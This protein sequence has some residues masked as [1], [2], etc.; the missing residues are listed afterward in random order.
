MSSGIRQFLENIDLLQHAEA[1]ESNDVDIDLLGELDDQV[2]KD[3]GIASAGHR[4]RILR[5]I[6]GPSAPSQPISGVVSARGN[7]QFPSAAD[8]ER[9]QLTVMFCDL[10]G[11]P[12]LAEQ[13]DPEELRDLMQAYQHA[14]GDIVARYEGHVAQY[15]GD[16]LVV[17]FGWPRAHEDDAAR[18]IGA[19]LE[20]VDAVS[21]LEAAVPI[22]VRVG[23]HTGLV[24]IGETGNGDASIPGGAVGDTPPR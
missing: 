14:C 24:V 23:I 17:Y 2:L 6:K 8:A 19:A 5:A 3:I 12:D 15:R 16:G 9:R 21:Q 4:L 10:V 22:R 1:F 13:L 11:F 20:M 18:T 7:Q